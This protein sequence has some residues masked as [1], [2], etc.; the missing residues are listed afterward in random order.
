MGDLI[1]TWETDVIHLNDE[2]YERYERLK[3]DLDWWETV[4]YQFK[5]FASQTG[6]SKWQTERWDMLYIVPKM[7]NSLDTDRMK[8]ENIMVVDAESGELIEVNAYDYFCTKK[9]FRS[10]Y[11]KVS[12]HE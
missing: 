9:K 11:V 10:P 6:V 8:S 5:K 3:S 2:M 7:T 1:K 4:K 12:E